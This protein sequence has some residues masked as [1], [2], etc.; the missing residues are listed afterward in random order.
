MSS[1]EQGQST[2]PLANGDEAVFSPVQLPPLPLSELLFGLFFYPHVVLLV[3]QYQVRWRRAL[4]V[5]AALCM[6]CGVCLGLAKLPR[7]FHAGQD[8]AAWLAREVRAVWVADS[9]LHWEQPTQLPYTTRHRGWRVDFVAEGTAF[10]PD[11]M[12]GPE[13]QGVWIAPENAFAWWRRA[14]G[15]VQCIRLLADSK[16]GGLFELGRIWPE[17]QRMRGEHFESETRRILVQAAPLI[18]LHEA[19]SVFFA[20]LAYALVFSFV[21]LLFRSTFI[22]KTF[23]SA[24]AFHLYASIP[25]LIVAS[26]YSGMGLPYL[27][28]NTVFVAALVGYLLLVFTKFRRSSAVGGPHG[29]A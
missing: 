9:K 19:I 11:E 23:W 24:F 13:R 28:F 16:A 8:W 1:R 6:L 29:M 17:N 25:P 27:D 20:V 2:P 3:V 26:V 22:A 14:H 12:T 7:V 10:Q 4:G 5:V 18:L 15:Q 21:P